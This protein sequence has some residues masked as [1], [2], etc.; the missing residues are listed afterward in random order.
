MLVA[1]SRTGRVSLCL[2]ALVSALGLVQCTI[3]SDFDIKQCSEASHCARSIGGPSFCDEGLCRPGCLENLDCVA[4]DPR[5]PICQP[6]SGRCVNLQTEGG[7]CFAATGYDESKGWTTDDLIVV[8]AFAPTIRSSTWLT[9]QLA[10]GEI[11]AAGGVATP[12][13]LRSLVVVL[14]DGARASIDITMDHLVRDLGVRAV[15]AS[16]DKEDLLSAFERPATNGEAVFLSTSAAYSLPQDPEDRLL[17]SLGGLY[18]EARQLYPP[19]IRRVSDAFAAGGGDLRSYRV[20]RIV[21]DAAE[22]RELDASVLSSIEVGG[23]GSEDLAREGR[24]QRFDL[25]AGGGEDFV[26]SLTRYAPHLVLVFAAGLS[27][28]SPFSERAAVISMLE[29]RFAETTVSPPTYVFGPRNTDDVSVGSLAVLDESFRRRAIG[30]RVDPPRDVEAVEGLASRFALTY[31]SLDPASG[32]GA[33][34]PTYDAL[35]YAALAVSSSSS[36]K[37]ADALEVV[38]GLMRVTDPAAEAV[39]IGPPASASIAV[40]ANGLRRANLIG[41]S[42][43]AGF[44][45]V[46]QYRLGQLRAYCWRAD[47]NATDYALFDVSLGDFVP[48]DSPCAQ[49]PLF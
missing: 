46:R 18:S 44:D 20:A 42:G 36:A 15:V 2:G 38:N 30:V 49:A 3:F 5:L 8:G 45:G 29:S 40:L 33:S 16:L 17:W 43:L 26:E 14:C 4:A 12:T 48:R 1:K 23:V 39:P 25:P 34:P 47:G 32:V 24:L 28:L 19:L 13:R 21:S 11:N 41:T 6:S 27:S 9:L 7:E 37:S 10:T 31:S 22:D 35:Y